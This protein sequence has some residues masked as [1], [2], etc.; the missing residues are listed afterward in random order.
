MKYV[1]MYIFVVNE[2]DGIII[3]GAVSS[4][5]Q[6]IDNVW[7]GLTRREIG[8]KFFTFNTF[9]H[10]AQEHSITCVYIYFALLV[11]YDTV[12]KNMRDG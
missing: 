12:W 5:L 10:R 4:N 2:K 1:P 9:L 7:F 11:L 3:Y 6:N 8:D